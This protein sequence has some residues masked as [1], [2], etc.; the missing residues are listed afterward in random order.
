MQPDLFSEG[1]E[2]G[3]KF[4]KV[5]VPGFDTFS[6]VTVR[7]IDLKNGKVEIEGARRGSRHRTRLLISFARARM[8]LH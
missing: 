7:R 5:K 6:T 4:Q 8:F 3:K 2:V 1:L